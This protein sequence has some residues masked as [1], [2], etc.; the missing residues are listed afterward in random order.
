MPLPQL[1]QMSIG[2]VG[3]SLHVVDL[4]AK[5]QILLP[6]GGELRAVVL[7]PCQRVLFMLLL[8]LVQLLRDIRDDLRAIDRQSPV[9]IFVVLG[10]L[11]CGTE[12]RILFFQILGFLY[13]KRLCIY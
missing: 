12:F 8:V 2:S 13:T 7:V 10:Y 4:L 1:P 3:G 9:L 5:I 11:E 6:L